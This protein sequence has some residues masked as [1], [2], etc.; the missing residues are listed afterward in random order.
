MG[1]EPFISV[2][3]GERMNPIPFSFAKKYILEQSVLD[4][5]WMILVR[6]NS[7]VSTV[8]FERYFPQKVP[9]C[10]ENV[11]ARCKNA[12]HERELENQRGA[13]QIQRISGMMR[14][15]VFGE[16]GWGISVWCKRQRLTFSTRKLRQYLF[17]STSPCKRIC[18]L[19]D[20]MVH[21]DQAAGM[22]CSFVLFFYFWIQRKPFQYNKRIHHRTDVAGK[23]CGASASE[24]ILWISNHLGFDQA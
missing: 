10:S 17:R 8:I 15:V 24:N 12:I 20:H 5:L 11:W 19:F 23:A 3:S 7:F 4:V 9:T 1:A 16:V 6:E 13:P 14:S 21:V 22:R 18:R 2:W